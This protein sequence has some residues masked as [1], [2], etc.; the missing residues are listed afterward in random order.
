MSPRT[1]VVA[2]MATTTLWACG[3]PPLPPP[4]GDEDCSNKKDDN[5]DGKTDCADPKCFTAAVC[6]FRA[7]VCNNGLD[8]N[9]DGK[10]DCA[11]PMC[12]AQLCGLGC[13][14]VAGGKA[15]SDCGDATDNDGDGF[16]DCSDPD[17]AGTSRCRD[18]GTGGGGGG[19]GVGGGGTGVGGGGAGG[20]GGGAG[21][22]GGGAGVGG[23]GAGVGGGGAGVGGG[24]AGVGGGGAGVG[25]GGGGAGVGGGGGGAGVGGGGAGVGGGGAG[26]GGGG[27]VPPNNG[28]QGLYFNGPSVYVTNSVFRIDPTIDFDWATGAPVAGININDFSVSW[29]GKVE[30]LYSETYTFHA[31]VDDGVRLWVGGKLIIDAWVDGGAREVSGTIALTAGTKAELRLEY[32]DKTNEAVMR[33][34]WSSPSQAKQVIPNARLFQP[35]VTS[36]GFWGDYFDNYFA[37]PSYI[38]HRVDGPVDFLWTNGPG[39]PSFPY[40]TEYGVRWTGY[41]I[42]PATGVYTFHT[43]SDDGVRLYVGGLKLIDNWTSH[44]PIEDSGAVTL[45]AGGR[46]L[47]RLD[48][49]Q[50]T[51]GAQIKLM[52]TLPAGV[53]TTIPAAE[54]FR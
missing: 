20:G 44:A 13:T 27:G 53:K 42:A 2:M 46:Y 32:Y 21:V 8:D 22:G 37:P 51:S 15:E 24:G 48:Y 25:G 9:D 47:V 26:V 33:L 30:A 45:T 38:G 11:D 23:G 16:K 18:A 35:T 36:A 3:S 54:L 52:W 29:T 5:G 50:N 17:C 1:A 31:Y 28:L 12:E 49:F 4:V 41:V 34:S 14:C 19:A 40:T 6:G 39:I 43:L 7:E 10:T